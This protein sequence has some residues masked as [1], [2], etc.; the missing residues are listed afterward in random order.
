LT[1][2][3]PETEKPEEASTD[4]PL[5]ESKDK[6]P[7][8]IQVYRIPQ[9]KRASNQ[10]TVYPYPVEP[11]SPHP[12][13]AVSLLSTTDKDLKNE[14]LTLGYTM[15]VKR[16]QAYPPC[17]YRIDYA[18]Q[19]ALRRY[20][21]GQPHTI[22][23]IYRW[24]DEMLPYFKEE[25]LKSNE[26]ERRRI[27]RMDFAKTV[28]NTQRSDIETEA[29]KQGLYPV[30]VRVGD[31]GSIGQLGRVWLPKAHWW[32]VGT[33]KLLGLTFYWQEP[34]DLTQGGQTIRLHDGNA[35]LIEGAW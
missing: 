12:R 11:P 23:E 16:V 22:G 26:D 10:F 3:A 25:I 8:V 7:L 19:K 15:R 30:D 21:G 2:P 1:N 27:E 31:N 18:Y 32:V 33:H 5:A 14:L 34:V 17:G 4:I 6:V 9:N 20:G 28:F 24:M 13:Y 29:N 35:L